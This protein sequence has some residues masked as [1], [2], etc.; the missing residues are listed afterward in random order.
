MKKMILILT[1]CTLCL[2]ITALSQKAIVGVTGGVSVANLNRT[3]GGVKNNGK[4]RD[5]I[6]SGIQLDIPLGKKNKVSFQPDLHY[7]QK[8][9]SFTPTSPSIDKIYTALHYAELTPNFVCNSHGNKGVFFIGGG[10]YV[11]FNLPSKKVTHSP[12]APSVSDDVSFGNNYS[13][14]IKNDFRGIDYGVNAIIGYRGN[15]GLT[16]CANFIQGL[17]N[18]VPGDKLKLAGFADDKIKNVVFAVRVGYFF[19]EK[20]KK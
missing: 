9:A 12:G 16:I 18:L 11:S 8:G 3:T 15:D 14:A 1:A 5:G 7:I 4:Y 17:R 6:I 19:K 20:R 2:Q 13:D 10:P